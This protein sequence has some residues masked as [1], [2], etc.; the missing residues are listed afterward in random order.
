M[1][2]LFRTTVLVLTL[3]FFHNFA[4]AQKPTT[5]LQLNDYLA[6]ITDSLFLG[7]REWGS[8]IADSKKSKK[9]SLLETPRKKLENFIERKRLEIVTMKDIGGSEKLRLAMLDF[10]AFESRM[11]KEAFLPF[12][13]FNN[14]TT[15]SDIDKALDNLN[16]IA[17]NESKFLNEVKK[18]QAAY[19]KKNGFTIEED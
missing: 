5:A 1:T 7:G 13:N 15:D 8:Q 11:I 16:E 18:S 17:A 9:F 2:F 4:F 14:K 12:E 19:A 10:L 3:T 6:D